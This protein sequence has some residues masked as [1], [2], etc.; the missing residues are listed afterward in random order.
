MYCSLAELTTDNVLEAYDFPTHLDG[1]AID[2]L[3]EPLRSA[4]AAT[5][6]CL[7]VLTKPAGQASN[8]SHDRVARNAFAVSLSSPFCIHIARL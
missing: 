8:D 1:W 3:L 7:V 2:D 5:Q 4:G 6:V